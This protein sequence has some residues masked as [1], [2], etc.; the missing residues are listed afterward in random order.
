MDDLFF[1]VDAYGGSGDIDV[2][3]DRDVVS[4]YVS[5]RKELVMSCH[6]HPPQPAC[7]CRPRQG[8]GAQEAT[9]S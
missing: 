1:I 6:V 5:H 3:I 9:L 7:C 8:N 2:D 4:V